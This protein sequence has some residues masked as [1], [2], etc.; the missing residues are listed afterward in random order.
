MGR[1][2]SPQGGRAL[3][4]V[5]SPCGLCG[6][7]SVLLSLPP[8]PHTGSFHTYVSVS[9]FSF[10]LSLFLPQPHPASLFLPSDACFFLQ[11]AF[12]TVLGIPPA[13]PVRWSQLSTGSFRMNLLPPGP[14]LPSGTF[15][16]FLFLLQARISCIQ[17]LHPEAIG[18]TGSPLWIPLGG[19]HLPGTLPYMGQTPG[20]HQLIPTG[21]PC[22]TSLLWAPSRGPR[23][24]PSLWD[25]SQP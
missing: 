19:L 14:R 5:C 8:L 3:L 17:I 24:S 13:R 4:G 21:V 25:I 11:P 2:P 7:Q 15:L 9:F 23:A 16:S 22:T 20:G 10:F 1:G 12:W 6:A 18:N